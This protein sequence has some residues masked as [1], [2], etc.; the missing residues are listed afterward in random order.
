MSILLEFLIYNERKESRDSI[1]HFTK[2]YTTNSQM[3][4]KAKMVVDY[5]CLNIPQNF[6]HWQLRPMLFSVWVSVTA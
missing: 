3:S 1:N 6:F 5:K 2:R 4:F